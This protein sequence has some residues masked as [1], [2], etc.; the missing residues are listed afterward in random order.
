[1]TKGTI[2]HIIGVLTVFAL[3]ITSGTQA[4]AQAATE[5]HCSFGM[6]KGQA[7][8]SCHVPIPSGCTVANVPG[9]EQ[10]WVDISK[11]G[12]T[13]CQFD[14]KESDWTTTI[15]GTCGPCTTEQCTARFSVM[16]NCTNA[17]T[18]PKMQLPNR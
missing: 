10:R 9:I 6:I 16:F 8:G 11:G 18:Q 15:V 17:M 4:W 1:M 7:N 13:S 14:E 12:Q 5:S 2:L 3:F